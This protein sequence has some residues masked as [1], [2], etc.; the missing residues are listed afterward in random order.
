MLVALEVFFGPN[1]SADR[2]IPPGGPRAY[3]R[4]VNP[5]VVEVSLVALTVVSFWLL[6]RYVTGLDVL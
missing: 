1:G 2:R 4:R 3:D 5:L 6:D